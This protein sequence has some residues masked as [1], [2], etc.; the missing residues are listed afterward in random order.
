VRIVFDLGGV[1]YRWQPDEFL[2]R[3]AP[4]R[5]ATPADARA[6]GAAFF[7][8]FDGD[9]SEFDRGAL[10]A[11]LLAART[12]A[13]LGLALEESRAIIDGVPQ[14]LQPVEATVAL[15]ARLRAAGHMLHFLSNMPRPYADALT[16]RDTGLFGLFTSGVFS[17]HVGLIKPDAAMFALAA[18]AFGAP[19]GELLLLD[20]VARNVAAAR[21]AGWQALIFRDAEQ[22]AQ[23]LADLGI[24]AGARQA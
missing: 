19:P 7:Q 11:P 23:E 4:M 10:E 2:M 15:A 8:S 13:R 3:L 12:A 22:C 6:F 1:V 21:E 24:G 5:A 17:S 16:T 20:D 9:W 14:E 18:R